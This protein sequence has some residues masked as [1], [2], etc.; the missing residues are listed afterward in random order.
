VESSD[1]TVTATCPSCKEVHL[2]KNAVLVV[3]LN[4]SQFSYYT[5]ICPSCK[6]RIRKP[7]DDHII[8]LLLKGGVPYELINLP[9]EAREAHTGAPLTYDDLLT[10]ALLLAD[11]DLLVAKLTRHLPR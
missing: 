3:I 9:A 1:K 11:D 10:F 8:Q 4:Y 2:D 6:V 7:A 5:F